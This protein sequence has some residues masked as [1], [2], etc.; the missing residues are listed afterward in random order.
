M[1]NCPTN[2]C[3]KD[4]KRWIFQG[5][6][7]LL[8][9]FSSQKEN[10]IEGL[11]RKYGGM[12]L[13]D[14]PSPPNSR[15]KRSSRSI[16]QQFPVILCLEKLETTKFLYGCAVNAFILKVDWLTDSI[17]SGSILPHDKYAILSNGADESTRLGKQP[18]RR[19]NQKYIFERV[20]IM[21][22]GK[23]SFCTKLAKIFKH[24]GGQVFKTLQW[25][26][27]SL[28]NEKISMGVIVAEDENRASRH[29]KHCAS[30]QE[31]PVMPASWIIKSLHSGKLLPISEKKHSSPL[32]RDNI[33]EDP[34]SMELSEEI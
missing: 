8:T 7:F 23:H 11:I 33:P 3:G 14:I 32:P 6:E 4:G 5:M 1:K 9:G 34:I 31:I 12:V 28:D 22:H 20:G 15:G 2:F 21:L 29:L 24:G 26:V 16:C 25:L 27:Q 17:A 30:E 13:F 18:V 10:E 19:N